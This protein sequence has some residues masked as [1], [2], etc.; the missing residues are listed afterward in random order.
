MGSKALNN[1][2]LIDLIG[3]QEL[4]YLFLLY[5]SMMFAR[6]FSIAVFMWKLSNLGYGLIWK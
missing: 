3:T 2:R 6:F 1:P 5:L 4:I